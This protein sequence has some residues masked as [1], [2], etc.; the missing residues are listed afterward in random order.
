MSA[1]FSMQGHNTPE[2]NECGIFSPMIY[3]QEKEVVDC[4]EDYAVIP[5]DANYA[6]SFL[7]VN[8]SGGKVECNF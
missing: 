2:K 6:W 3:N 5:G 7:G 4:I 8:D 1:L